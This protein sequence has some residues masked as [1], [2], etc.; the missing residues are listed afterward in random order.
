MR[1]KLHDYSVVQE[2]T[3]SKQTN[4]MYISRKKDHETPIFLV[5]YKAICMVDRQ[6]KFHSGSSFMKIFHSNSC[7]M[8]ITFE[9]EKY[10]QKEIII[11][12]II[13]AS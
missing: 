5:F 4:K 10:V 2:T 8:C 12:H 7:H 3:I 9:K 11:S 6:N 13:E 1:I